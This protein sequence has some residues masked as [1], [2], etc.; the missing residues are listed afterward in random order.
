MADTFY[1]P[2]CRTHLVKHEDGVSGLLSY[3]CPEC[4][5]STGWTDMLP[6][7]YDLTQ[8]PRPYHID[9]LHSRTY[10][11]RIIWLEDREFPENSGPLHYNTLDGWAAD[12]LMMQDY[13]KTWRCWTGFPAPGRIN[14]TPWRVSL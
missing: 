13:N 9:E 2:N 6:R 10:L 11:G 8:T 5:F 3:D 12:T 7:V 1:C 14:N 4:R